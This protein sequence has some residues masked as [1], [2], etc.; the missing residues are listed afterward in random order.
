MFA[1]EMATG[2][3]PNSADVVV[4]TSAGAYVGALV[5]EDALHLDS[6]ARPT[7]TD[8]DIAM[9]I[10]SHVYRRA[11]VNGFGRWL[12]HGVI[13]GLRRPGLTMML[14]CPAPYDP[15]GISD[16]LAEQAGP[17]VD[18]W[19]PRPTVIVAFDI[20]AKKRVAFGT[21]EAPEVTLREAVAASSAIP[22]LFHPY[23]INGSAYV[24]GGVASGTHADLVLGNPEPLDLVIVLAPL[25]AEK[26]RNGAALY[27]QLLDHAGWQRLSEEVELIEQAWPDSKVLV[28]RPGEDVLSVMR[29]NPMRSDAAVSSFIGSLESMHGM[30]SHPSVW[31]ILE[32]H[33]GTAA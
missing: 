22:V 7:D 31:S 14:G 6:I 4:G 21:H 26:T 2:W 32:T 33:L 17:G 15:A 29:S 20:S 3:D 23:E 28:L 13:P 10:R 12:R 5:R 18:G 8:V 1:I 19:P 27:E 16:W 24:D 9:R 25:A 30:L 11:K